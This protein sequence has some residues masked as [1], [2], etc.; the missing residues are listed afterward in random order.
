M[1][2]APEGPIPGLPP[3]HT[4]VD[5]FVYVYD[6]SRIEKG[7]KTLMAATIRTTTIQGL[8]NKFKLHA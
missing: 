2:L 3:Q 1:S 6:V 4:H 7:H 8:P 5:T